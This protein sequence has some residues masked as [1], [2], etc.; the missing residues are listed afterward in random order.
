[1]KGPSLGSSLTLGLR[2]ASH[3]CLGG[4][5]AGSWGHAQAAQHQPQGRTPSPPARRAPSL[6]KPGVGAGGSPMNGSWPHG[7]SYEHSVAG[8]FPSPPA[9]PPGPPRCSPEATSFRKPTRVSPSAVMTGMACPPAD[10]GP[11]EGT[12]H[13]PTPGA[14]ST[15]PPRPRCHCT[16]ATASASGTAN[17]GGGR[18]AAVA[19]P[20]GP[21]AGTPAGQARQSGTHRGR[22]ASRAPGL[23]QPPQRDEAGGGGAA[24]C[25]DG[26]LGHL[27]AVHVEPHPGAA[28]GHVH[29]QAG[30]AF[31]QPWPGCRTRLGPLPPRWPWLPS[32]KWPRCAHSGPSRNM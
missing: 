29:L 20:G 8:S 32:E 7:L 10:S 9:G 5:G 24:H 13:L 1:M 17:Q 2:D 31:P 15:C 18:S 16:G 27:P 23:G 19:L 6:A 28:H 14:R 21:P 4:A 22:A 11:Q 30:R 12:A 3:P 26:P 25:P